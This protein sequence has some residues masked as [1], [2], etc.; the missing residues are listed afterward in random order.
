MRIVASLGVP[1]SPRCTTRAIDACPE[2]QRNS[3]PSRCTTPARSAAAHMSS[4]SAASRANGFSHKT[5]LPASI[6]SSVI[7]A[8]VNGGVATATASTP[9]SDERVLE[10]RQPVRHLEA[11]G[12][13]S[14]LLLVA[15]DERVHVEAGC[16]QRAQVGDATEAGSHDHD[17]GHA[18][19]LGC[20]SGRSIVG[21]ICGA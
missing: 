5:C 7:A 4:A 20:R 21:C 17:A 18:R 9:G 13:R 10:G 11:V 12:A 2:D 15:A 19:L 3:V 16:A 6:A 14:R 1:I 8:W